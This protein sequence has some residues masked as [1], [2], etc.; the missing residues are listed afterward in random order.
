M[1]TYSFSPSVN[2][3]RDKDREINYIRTI[4]GQLTFEQI[5]ETANS[6]ARAFTIIGA[7]GSGKST[8]LWA[9]ERAITVE[10]TFFDHFD[11]FLKGY[12]TYHTLDIVWEFESLQAV[13]SKQLG[14]AVDGV[15]EVFQDR[16]RGRQ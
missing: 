13:I 11:Y 4:N 12:S 16:A 2:I 7:Y 14:V 8:F 5:V 15:S 9:L 3:I 6:G 1:Q 10:N